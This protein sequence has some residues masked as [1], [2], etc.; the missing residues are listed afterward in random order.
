MRE[1]RAEYS[2]APEEVREDMNLH[3]F[4]Q[5]KEDKHR[6]AYEEDNFKRVAV[7]KQEKVR[8]HVQRID[9]ALY[10]W[11]LKMHT[12]QWKVVTNAC[13]MQGVYLRVAYSYY[14]TI[15]QQFWSPIISV[16]Y[17]TNTQC[18]WACIRWISNSLNVAPLTASKWL[19]LISVFTEATRSAAD[20][21]FA[22]PAHQVWRYF[23]FDWRLIGCCRWQKTK[24]QV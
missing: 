11:S 23:S 20:C 17:K 9:G 15:L 7:S 1:L 12:Q 5:S 3:R 19:S 14:L 24:I 16:F 8:G 13:I 22:R 10:K 21:L 6:I 18:S 4:K 2:E